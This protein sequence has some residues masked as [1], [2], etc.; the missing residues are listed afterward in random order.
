MIQERNLSPGL[1]ERIKNVS[2]ISGDSL[3]VAGNNTQALTWLD[4]RVPSANLFT[5]LDTAV[6]SCVLDRGDMIKVCPGYTGTIS[7]AG[8]VTLDVPGITIQ[9][10]GV[11]T[12]M[13]TLT[14]DTATTATLL[15]SAANVSMANILIDATGVDAIARPID[16]RAAGFWMEKCEVYFAKTSFVALKAMSVSSAAFG[17]RLTLIGNHFH[18][19]AVASC[20]NALEILG[21]DGINIRGNTIVGNFTVGL[22]CTNVTVDGNWLSNRTALANKVAV[23]VASSTGRFT[24]NRI[25]YA[26]VLSVLPLTGDAI[27]CAGNYFCSGF[28]TVAT[29]L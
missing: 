28:A 27:A 5:S 4:G 10:F 13:P 26:T 12:L 11:G 29:L 19:D 25:S 23:F 1:L 15:V 21:G 6:G 8:G 16:I 7:A 3:Y 18:G 2:P 22:G 24:N 17:N 9:G 14:L 20:T